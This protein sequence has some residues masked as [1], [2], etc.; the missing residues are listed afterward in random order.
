MGRSVECTSAKED[1]KSMGGGSLK[2]PCKGFRVE[3]EKSPGIQT[4]WTVV[5]RQ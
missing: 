5:K 3:S 4:L 1:S 2:I